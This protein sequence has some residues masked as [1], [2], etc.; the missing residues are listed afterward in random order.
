MQA[1]SFIV[2][3]PLVCLGIAF[4]AIVVFVEWLHKRTGDPL[5]LVLA[6]R[7]TKIMVALFA[8]GVIKGTILSFET[9]DPSGL[10]YLSKEQ[11]AGQLVAD[12]AKRLG[13]KGCG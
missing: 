4:L 12:A 10:S 5:Y 1:L 11:P 7:W 9:G 2:H 6:K 8:V 13:A 3:I